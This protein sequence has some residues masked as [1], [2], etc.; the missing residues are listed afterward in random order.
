[1]YDGLEIELDAAVMRAAGD[2]EALALM[3]GGDRGGRGGLGSER[4]RRQVRGWVG[5]RL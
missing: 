1:V 2:E 4:R 3:G 5:A